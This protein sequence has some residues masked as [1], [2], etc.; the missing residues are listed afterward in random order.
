MPSQLTAISPID[1]RYQTAVSNLSNYFSEYALFKYRVWIEVEYFIALSEHKYFALN[2]SQKKALRGLYE[3]FTV[4]DAEAIKKI[5]AVTRHDVKAVEY[6]IKE[7]MANMKLA[8]KSEWVHFG[9]TSQD[10]NNTAVPLSWKHAIEN[11][12]IPGKIGPIE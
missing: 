5:E 4:K 2:A 3:K 11:E 7:K 1:G 9:L 10:I 6:F 12:Y 8:A